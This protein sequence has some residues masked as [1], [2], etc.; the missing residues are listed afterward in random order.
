MSGNSSHWR[1][2]PIKA[3]SAG[4]CGVWFVRQLEGA[5]K[6]LPTISASGTHCVLLTYKTLSEESEEQMFRVQR[7][8]DATSEAR[9][10]RPTSV[11]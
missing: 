2:E 8:A 1:F 9:A 11:C 6:A 5:E 4:E 10:F 7:S 3:F